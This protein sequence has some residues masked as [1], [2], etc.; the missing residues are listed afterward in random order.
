MTWQGLRESD[1]QTRET[2]F[3]PW[4]WY[5]WPG[6]VSRSYFRI[7]FCNAVHSRV[8][9]VMAENSLERHLSFFRSYSGNLKDGGFRKKLWEC[10][11]HMWGGRRAASYVAIRWANSITGLDFPLCLLTACSTVVLQGQELVIV[12]NNGQ[13]QW[14]PAF[15]KLPLRAVYDA[16]PIFCPL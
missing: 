5:C 8:L 2:E 14:A 4:R 7:L 12:T 9:W 11:S 13:Q 15:M 3:Y 10:A 16:L 6:Q 1:C